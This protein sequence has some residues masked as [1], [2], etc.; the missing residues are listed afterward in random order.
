MYSIN[1]LHC[2]INEKKLNILSRIEMIIFFSSLTLPL[3]SEE[4]LH[5]NSPRSAEI[6]LSYLKWRHIQGH[7]AHNTSWKE[8]GS[9]F[10]VECYYRSRLRSSN[11][12]CRM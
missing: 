9:M 5:P 2:R 3:L 11:H 12:F 10:L 8:S 4:A 7:C 1:S 6:L